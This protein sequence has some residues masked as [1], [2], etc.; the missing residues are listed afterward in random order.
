[1]ALD[2]LI[3]TDRISKDPIG[4]DFIDHLQRGAQGLALDDA[5]LYYD[6]PI[7]S[8]YETVAHKPDVLLASRRHGLLAIRFVDGLEASQISAT[9]LASVDESLAQ[10]CSILIGRL[11]KSRL[12]RLNLSTLRFPVT[13][14]VLA[15]SAVAP[16]TALENSQVVTSL[17]RF[18]ELL[19]EIANETYFEEEALAETRSVIEG[20]KALSRPQKRVI[21]DNDIQ[22]SA[23]ALAKLEAEIANFVFT[24]LPPH[25]PSRS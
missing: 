18:D 10:F 5:A 11:L 7:F 21:E 14:V 15:I 13:P 25:R 16:C 1:L 20:A 17:A 9:T 23:V 3:T 22:R 8:D 19:R 24:L 6:F 2:I 12:L 4:R